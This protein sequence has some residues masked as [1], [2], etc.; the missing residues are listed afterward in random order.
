MGNSSDLVDSKIGQ[1]DSNDES[2]SNSN[3]NSQ[4]DENLSAKFSQFSVQ[5]Q[6]SSEMR[7]K[8]RIESD[9]TSNNLNEQMI[10]ST[11]VYKQLSISDKYRT[12]DVK[13]LILQKFFLSPDLCDKYSL[14][15]VLNGD[16][17][18]SGFGDAS[19]NSELLISD[20]DNVFYA[21]KKVPDMQFVLRSKTMVAKLNELPPQSPNHHGASSNGNAFKLSGSNSKL[22]HSYEKN[23]GNHHH[24]HQKYWFKKWI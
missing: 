11:V 15:Q 4:A 23:S 6:G 21:A 24:N 16:S 9:H 10:A 22:N 8:V 20:K 13:R 5:Q 19:M 3:S 1:L 17:L 14:V 12:K 7:V 2:N 18:S